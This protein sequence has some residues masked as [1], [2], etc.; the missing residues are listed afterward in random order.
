MTT[1]PPVA[2]TRDPEHLPVSGD[3]YH[4]IPWH[5]EPSFYEAMEVVILNGDGP[6]TITSAEVEE[7]LA[8]D[9]THDGFKDRQMFDVAVN[10]DDTIRL[11]WSEWMSWMRYRDPI[12]ED[13][14]R[15]KEIRER[16]EED[17]RGPGIAR[18]RPKARPKKATGR[19]TPPPG[20]EQP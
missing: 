11:S 2:V 6:R 18:R 7:M 12:H 13:P 15:A 10:G 9:R 17:R 19:K 5:P 4:A 20:K 16:F 14:A 8:V 1:T 3:G